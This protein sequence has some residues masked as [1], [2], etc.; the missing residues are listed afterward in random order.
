MSTAATAT[1]G[2]APS[3]LLRRPPP[4]VAVRG[5]PGAVPPRIVVTGRLLEHATAATEPATGRAAFSVVIG[6]PG[7]APPILATRWSGDGPDAAAHARDRAA[8]LPRGTLVTI[9]GDG[10]SLR[11]RDGALAIVIAGVRDVQEQPA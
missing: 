4:A 5:E 8:A 9:S 7:G 3:A 11:Y 2:A 1:A 6:Q 10:M